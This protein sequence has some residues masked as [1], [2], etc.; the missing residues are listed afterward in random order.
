[1][2]QSSVLK[3]CKKDAGLLHLRFAMT[4]FKQNDVQKLDA[5]TVSGR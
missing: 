3:M 2:K 1:V 5:F 4:S